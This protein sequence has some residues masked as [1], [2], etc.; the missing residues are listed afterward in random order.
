MDAVGVAIARGN[1]CNGVMGTRIGIAV[2]NVE[3]SFSA[4]VRTLFLSSMVN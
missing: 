1:V 2:V 4:T 3:E